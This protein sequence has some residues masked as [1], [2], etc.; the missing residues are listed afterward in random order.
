MQGRLAFWICAG[1]GVFSANAVLACLG[2]L[3]DLWYQVPFL[4]YLPF[5]L[6][7]SQGEW[8]SRGLWGVGFSVC[9]SPQRC[10][11]QGEE[12]TAPVPPSPC[13]RLLQRACGHLPPEYPVLL[14][15]SLFVC[16]RAHG[17]LPALAFL[18]RVPHLPVAFLPGVRG[19]T[20]GARCP[21]TKCL[22]LPS[23]IQAPGSWVGPQEAGTHFSAWEPCFHGLAALP[24]ARRRTVS[25]TPEVGLVLCGPRS[26]SYLIIFCDCLK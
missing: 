1:F 6:Y 20:T 3:C 19:D 16:L 18:V 5:E 23:F 2:L 11:L 24:E 22:S 21:H 14:R 25:S 8:G 7:L 17:G 15:L 26:P 13:P 9:H 12:A 10:L 4:V